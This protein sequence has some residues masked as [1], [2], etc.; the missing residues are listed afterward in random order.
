MLS[1]IEEI[2]QITDRI[3]MGLLGNDS[4]ALR[5][6]KDAKGGDRIFL[7]VVYEA[8]CSKTGEMLPWK[9]RK[10]YLSDHMLE[11]EIIFTAFLAYELAIKHEIMESFKVDNITLVNPHVNYKRLLEISED[12]VKRQAVVA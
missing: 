12:E 11:Q 3:K 4:F 9:G 6:E 2:K 8:P 10:F 7:Q 1:G 5:V